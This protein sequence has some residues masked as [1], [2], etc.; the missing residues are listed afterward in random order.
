VLDERLRYQANALLF[1]HATA[2]LRKNGQGIISKMEKTI[3]SQKTK[4]Y[5]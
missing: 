3:N 2:R 1:K 4:C 5:F